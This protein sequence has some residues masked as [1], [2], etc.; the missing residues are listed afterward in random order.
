MKNTIWTDASDFSKKGG[1]FLDK[2]FISTMGSPYM[3]STG[4]GKP[5]EDAEYIVNIPSAGKY[6][7]WVRCR[8]WLK[9]SSPGTFHLVIGEKTS[10]IF[11]NQNSD[12]WTWENGGEF[13]LDAGSLIVKL[14]DNSG[15]WGR[16]A[17]F[18]LSSD[19]QFL[20][21]SDN[22][23]MRKQKFTSREQSDHC[24]DGGTFQVIVAGAGI[25]GCCAAIAS[26]RGKA[27]T[28]L[29]DERDLPGGNGLLGVPINGAGDFN[30][31]SRES[32]IVDE[33]TRV[34]VIDNLS[35]SAALD[36][37][38]K[39]EP[40]LTY[41]PE[42][43]ILSSQ[44]E[45]QM[46]HQITA[47]DANTDIRYTYNADIFCDCTG[48]A[49][50]GVISGAEYRCGR[51]SKEEF[52]EYFAPEKPDNL[53][54]SGVLFREA[55][56]YNA[57]DT[58]SPVSFTPP[59][60]AYSF[61]DYNR[62]VC[63]VGAYDFNQGT[64]WH[65]H[66]GNVNEYTDPE[67]GRDE[68]FRIVLGF[69]D[70]VKNYWSFRQKS[71]NYTLDRIAV[72][73]AKRE[74]NRLIGEYIL[75][76]KDVEE[77]A[78]FEDSVSMGGWPIDLHN[79]E[80]IFAKSGPYESSKTVMPYEIPY[81]CL[82]SKNIKNLLMAGRNVSVTHVALGTVR[83]QGTLGSLGQA[84]GIAAALCAQNSDLPSV[85]S[86]IKLPTLLHACFCADL[87]FPGLVW[88]DFRDIVP[89]ATSL[90]ATST[91]SY[92]EFLPKHMKTA[93]FV[94][95]EE[96]RIAVFPLGLYQRIDTLAI[97]V[98]S[99][100]PCSEYPVSITVEAS[101]DSDF[102]SCRLV[103]KTIKTAVFGED[104]I[105]SP[106]GN[107]WY[108][109]EYGK[110][111]SVSLPINQ[112][113]PEKYVRLTVQGAA[114]LYFLLQKPDELQQMNGS[115]I[116]EGSVLNDDPFAFTL[117]NPILLPGDH[118]TTSLHHVEN[119]RNGVNRIV[120]SKMNLWMSDPTLSLPQS[121]EIQFSM[122]QTIDTVELIF[123][124][125]LHTSPKAFKRNTPPFNVVQ[126]YTIEWFDGKIWRNIVQCADNILRQRIHSF[127][128]VNVLGLRFTAL[129]TGG[130][131]SARLFCLRA[132]Q[133]R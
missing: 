118:I 98:S 52:D 87:Y 76:Q 88:Q 97:P 12:L 114:H 77:G 109:N 129:K 121:V 30:P 45:K 64:W 60:W 4:I 68:L 13:T 42:K 65:E 48:D 119:I 18:I 46:I 104:M 27:R 102:T 132:Y 101:D 25:A 9:E 75:T 20:P 117:S 14:C 29:I 8:N 78:H 124:T 1:W 67:K 62:A 83:V 89:Q 99:K 107:T 24:V 19:P 50:L 100:T 71:T 21:S 90:S 115:V 23:I 122:Q 113:I 32:G 55:F 126:D 127:P 125:D 39:A 35:L 94:P 120:G 34:Q 79:K 91:S 43:V 63:C 61:P 11:G 17:S 130:D 93:T 106:A 36:K 108:G 22:E 84:A 96:T 54:M 131:L 41:L 3:I 44:T 16:M 58:G 37:L 69:W 73:L 10:P 112:P 85:Y 111:I 2:Q 49:H 110:R 72:T 33:I 51:E 133:N 31:D 82:Y 80:G 26:A 47:T 81:R 92:R 28:L 116:R 86:Q 40:Y 15:Y 95:S 128:A 57:K 103:T 105:F 53:L 6:R 66:H 7:L 123:D 5:V 59:S 70:Y 56:L 38:I 74:S